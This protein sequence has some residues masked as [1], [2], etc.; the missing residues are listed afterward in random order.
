MAVVSWRRKFRA[1]MPVDSRENWKSLSRA[2]RVDFGII[3]GSSKDNFVVL[4][5][6]F[7]IPVDFGR[8]IFNKNSISNHFLLT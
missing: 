5:I 8:F 3:R 1:G 7:D 4:E 6:Y 2:S